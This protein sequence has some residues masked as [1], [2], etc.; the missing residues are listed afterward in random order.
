[1][2]RLWNQ[3]IKSKYIRKWSL[4]SWFRETNSHIHLALIKQSEG[5]ILM[6]MGVFA[7]FKMVKQTDKKNHW[8]MKSQSEINQGF[9][10]ENE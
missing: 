6:G 10:S 5:Q 1:M 4:V 3:V 7:N 2:E 8:E 9:Y